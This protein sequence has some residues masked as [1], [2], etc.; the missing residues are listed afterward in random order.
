MHLFWAALAIFA[1]SSCE[2]FEGDQDGKDDVIDEPIQGY[3][4]IQI[5]PRELFV[6]SSDGIYDISVWASE[7]WSLNTLD[8]EYDWCKPSTYNGTADTDESSYVSFEVSANTD[9]NERIATWRFSTNSSE[10]IFTLIQEGYNPSHIPCTISYTTTDDNPISL[11]D[12]IES[13][14][15]SIAVE[16]I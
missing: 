4:S 15:L 8:E 14:L 6:P 1:L 12:N 3:D 7:D 2:L 10:V 13:Y 11:R 16:Q 9:S 5:D